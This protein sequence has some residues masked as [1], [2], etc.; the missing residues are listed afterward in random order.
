MSRPAPWRPG[1]PA[2][3]GHVRPGVF[4]FVRP[5]PR[6]SFLGAPGDEYRVG[7]HQP[8]ASLGKTLAPAGR[9]LDEVAK[10]FRGRRR[11]V[12]GG[13]G[14][15][16]PATGAQPP[17]DGLQHVGAAA[18]HE[19]PIGIGEGGQRLGG[20]GFDD[21]QCGTQPAAVLLDAPGVVGP[22]FNRED[23][24]CRAQQGAFDAA[25]PLPAPT[26]HSTP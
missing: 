24:Q 6:S 10:A 19:H 7:R 20:A 1:R 16:H 11:P 23:P 13:E 8:P 26:S 22:V 15:H 9:H 2:P 4:G 18:A 17:E 5:R 12:Q 14:G 3:I 21:G 25:L